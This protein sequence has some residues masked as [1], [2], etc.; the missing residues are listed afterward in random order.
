MPPGLG[1]PFQA[2]GDVDA[3]AEDVVAVGEDVSDIDAD[4]EFDP[5]LGRPVG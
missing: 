4:A 1:D 3:V 5:P 2:G